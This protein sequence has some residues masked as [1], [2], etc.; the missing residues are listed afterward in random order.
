MK[1]NRTIPEKLKVPV[2]KPKDV[3]VKNEATD[4]AVVVVPNG[5]PDPETDFYIEALFFFL[6]DAFAHV[7]SQ[8]DSNTRYVADLTTDKVLRDM[9]DDKT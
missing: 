5:A 3:E 7:R 1:N 2:P 6:G 8:N 4:Y 9:T